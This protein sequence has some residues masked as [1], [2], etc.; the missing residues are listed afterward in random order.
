MM[1]ASLANF[2]AA[3]LLS[4]AGGAADQPAAALPPKSFL[5]TL[6]EILRS[7]AD[8]WVT[9]AGGLAI[10]I[11]AVWGLDL[12]WKLVLVPI[13]VRRKAGSLDGLL[14]KHAKRPAQLLLAIVGF[15]VVYHVVAE[16]A[17]WAHSFAAAFC[18][19]ALYAAV[20]LAVALLGYAVFAAFCD[21]YLA[22]VAA[23]TQST[24]DDRLVPVFRRV[25]KVV[26]LFLA[27]TVVLGHFDVKIAALL[28]AAGVASLAVAL[29]AQET[30]ANMISGFTILVDRP[31]RMGDRIQL[32]DGTVGDVHEIGLRSTKIMTFDNTLLILPN[33]E[34]SGARIVNLSYPDPR[35]AIRKDYTVAYGSDVAKAKRLLVE[36]AAAHLKVL[37]DPPPTAFFM[38]FGASALVIS[39]TCQVADYRDAFATIDELNME[40]NRRFAAEGLEMPFPQRDI[41]IR[42]GKLG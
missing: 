40:I 12:F 34:I 25:G 23:K 38:D 20:V 7:L 35:F 10:I 21:W 13:I 41:H 1:N 22:S 42:S 27:L 8:N 9:V 29:A 11:A 18:E 37:K 5:A 6:T 36:I 17:S 15:K 4:G 24:A 3:V 30:V 28:G 16:G 32:A 19:G 33:K 31:F 26:V 14:L 2:C 39:L